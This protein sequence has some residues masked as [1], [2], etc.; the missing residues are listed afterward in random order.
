[1]IRRD[2]VLGQDRIIFKSLK[3]LAVK[4]KVLNAAI[5]RD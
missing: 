4:I 2:V 5:W 1:M 3:E